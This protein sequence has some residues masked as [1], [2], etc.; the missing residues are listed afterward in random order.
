M[1]MT[2]AQ[3]L[4]KALQDAIGSI[5]R[6][7][8]LVR[9]TSTSYCRSIGLAILVTTFGEEKAKVLL[10]RSRL[11]ALA[12]S[13]VHVLPSLASLVII[14]INLMTLYIGEELVGELLI[15]GSLATIIFDTLR[16]RLVTDRGVPLGLLGSGFAFTQVS[17]FWSTDFL[18]S[19][20]YR[21]SCLLRKLFF[22]G[23]LLVSG[24]IA[25]LAGP[26]TAVLMIPR[27]MDWPMGGAH[28]WLNGDSSLNGYDCSTNTSKFFDPVCPSSGYK[29]TYD[30]VDVW[31]ALP[32]NW[33]GDFDL[34]DTKMRKSVQYR[35]RRPDYHGAH[36]ATVRFIDDSWAATVHAPAANMLL[37]A[38]S[39]WLDAVYFA[40]EH[41]RWPRVSPFAWIASYPLTQI[42]RVQADLPLVRVRCDTRVTQLS[43]SLSESWSN[44]SFPLVPVNDHAQSD[45][46]RFEVLG[47]INKGRLRSRI[48]S[49]GPKRRGHFLAV[50]LMFEVGTKNEK[51]GIAV[52]WPTVRPNG[53]LTGMWTARGCT[54]L[55]GW[56]EGS[57]VVNFGGNTQIYDFER[58]QGGPRMEIDKLLH[59][60]GWS[61]F[62]PHDDG[63][64]RKIFVDTSWWDIAL[65]TLDGYNLD[66]RQNLPANSTTLESVLAAALHKDEFADGKKEEVA[67]MTE[68]IISTLLVDTIS[69]VSSHRMLNYSASLEPELSKP[70]SW[71]RTREYIIAGRDP[72]VTM[73]KPSSGA[74]TP[75][76]MRAYFHGFV[77]AA[78]GWFDYF[79]IVLLV[80]HAV[81]AL[82][83]TIKTVVFSPLTGDA[84]ETIPEMLALAQNSPPPRDDVLDNTCAGVRKWGT[85]AVMAWV[86]DCS[87]PA[88][89]GSPK[90]ELKL[91]FGKK[92]GT[93]RTC[94]TYS[95]PDRAY[96]KRQANVRSD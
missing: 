77:I 35:L 53:T 23:L 31:H 59:D 71:A 38:R 81:M 50:P 20:V 66:S 94:A 96:G 93:R 68:L 86:E 6:A 51:Q 57:I 18:G 78:N 61:Y 32:A 37:A 49:A 2:W 95:M 14:T 13:G 25:V 44:I 5:A 12:R 60:W 1:P 16:H 29:A 19:L 76:T 46:G 17:F 90:E 92:V 63:T 82:A 91:T 56:A 52:L 85:S 26:A 67:I 84:W 7:A 39:L 79:S 43:S 40:V 80:L 4:V 15:V 75:M 54:H 73:P 27:P 10:R 58:D 30:H 33:L 62:L 24:G 55:S 89:S 21:D 34:T 47:P 64:W 74:A 11:T 42:H 87:A 72:T 28:I 48:A 45:R 88:T 36:G 41:A 69:R 3:R 70:W 83:F 8:R 65:P 9:D 22:I